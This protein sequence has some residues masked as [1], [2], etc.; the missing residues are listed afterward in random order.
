MACV[1]SGPQATYGLPSTFMWFANYIWSFLNNHIDYEN[2][3]NIKNI[4]FTT[5][6]TL[7]SVYMDMYWPEDTLSL[8]WPMWPA[9]PKESPTPGL[10]FINVLSTAFAHADP[11]SGKRYWWLNCIF[12][13][14]RIH[15]RRRLVKLTPSTWS[16][17][18][19]HSVLTYL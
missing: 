2:T 16:K 12:Y 9:K 5:K 17:S 8:M 15:E 7:K 3:L 11:E 14:L 18:M 19:I 6:T 1:T 13:A 4:C 10:N